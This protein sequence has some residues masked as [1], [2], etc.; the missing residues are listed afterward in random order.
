MIKWHPNDGVMSEGMMEWYPND[1]LLSEWTGNDKM[2]FK[3]WN[4]I[5][6][7]KKC[8]NELRM[9]EWHPNDGILSEWTGNDEMILKW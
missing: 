8:K 3:L 5:W 4:D 2:I 1:E 7:M 9:I 6:M